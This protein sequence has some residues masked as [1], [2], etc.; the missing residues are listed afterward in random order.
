[1]FTSRRNHRSWRAKR[2]FSFFCSLPRVFSL[3]IYCDFKRRRK[4]ETFFFERGTL[5]SIRS[6][7]REMYRKSLPLSLFSWREEL[8]KRRPVDKTILI[9]FDR[10]LCVHRR[11]VWWFTC[12]APRPPFSLK[13]RRWWYLRTETARIAVNE[14][15]CCF[16]V[17]RQSGWTSRTDRNRWRSSGGRR[18][19][20]KWP[21]PIWISSV[22]LFVSNYRKCC[23]HP[24][25]SFRLLL[26]WWFPFLFRATCS[27]GQRRKCRR[28][29]PSALPATCSLWVWWWR[30]SSIGAGHSSRP[31]TATPITR[32]K[33]KW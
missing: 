6:P 23:G 17:S 15:S 27:T 14:L 30:P 26:Y 5:S 28:S 33:W 9:P 25:I 10:S 19:S 12:L 24:F 29:R 22:S 2:D 20:L 16:S 3:F 32:S 1:M 11:R 8:A 18:G 13:S 4:L 21:N 7:R 31:I